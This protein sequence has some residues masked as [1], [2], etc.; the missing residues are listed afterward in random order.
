MTPE[1]L[2]AFMRTWHIATDTV[3]NLRLMELLDKATVED[4]ENMGK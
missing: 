2:L 3:N 4:Q 1:E